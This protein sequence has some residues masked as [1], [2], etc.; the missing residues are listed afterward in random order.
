MRLSFGYFTPDDHYEVLVAR[1]VTSGC[2]W[3]DIGC[4]RDIFPSNPQLARDLV[5]RAAVI[6]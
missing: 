4:G 5:A 6:K 1:L 3:A 2:H